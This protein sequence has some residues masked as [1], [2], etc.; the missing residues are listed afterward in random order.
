MTGA[1]LWLTACNP[2]LESRMYFPKQTAQM[3]KLIWS[4]TVRIWN[5]T[6][7]DKRN[8][9]IKASCV[10]IIWSNSYLTDRYLTHS[11]P[12]NCTIYTREHW[13]KITNWW[14]KGYFWRIRRK[15]IR[16]KID[17]TRMCKDSN[18]SWWLQFCHFKKWKKHEVCR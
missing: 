8:H 9:C 18:F 3:H 15:F 13:A 4:Y 12:C 11:L 6:Q 1:T 2:I 5:I 10:K 17:V 7:K 14:H 16:K